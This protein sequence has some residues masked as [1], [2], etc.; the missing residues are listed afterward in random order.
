[1]VSGSLAHRQRSALDDPL[2]VGIAMDGI[3]GHQLFIEQHSH[4]S[5]HVVALRVSRQ[6][7]GETVGLK[8]ANGPAFLGSISGAYQGD[9]S[10]IS[11]FSTPGICT[12]IG[13]YAT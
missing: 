12:F 4:T 3:S 5:G 8:P 9:D 6:D 13:L 10:N 2:R 7:M 11:E 1:M